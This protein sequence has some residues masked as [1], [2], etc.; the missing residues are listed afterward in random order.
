MR[1]EGEENSKV[2]LNGI[3]LSGG[4]IRIPAQYSNNP[5]SSNQLKSLKIRHCTLLPTNSP[6]IITTAA[7]TTLISRLLVELPGLDVSI[8]KSITGSIRA[9]EGA[10]ISIVDSIVDALNK[11]AVAYAAPDSRI[12]RRQLGS[13]ELHHNWKN[14]YA[15]FK[16][17]IELHFRC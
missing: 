2:I 15:Y 17:G 10:K 6:A 14:P 16:N 11:S 4:Q 13:K 5:A 7:E 1:I 9:V 12:G 3:L 8:E